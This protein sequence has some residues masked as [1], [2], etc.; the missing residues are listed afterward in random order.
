MIDGE[1]LRRPEESGRK[2]QVAAAGNLS[3]CSGP[4]GACLIP[5]TNA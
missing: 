2:P 5:G 1:P 4:S 3:G